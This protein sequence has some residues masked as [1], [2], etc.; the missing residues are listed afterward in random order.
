MK[1]K[2]GKRGG[3]LSTWYWNQED[4]VTGKEAKGKIVIAI[5]NLLA[6]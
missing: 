1:G 2:R 4:Q 6:I 3:P 5:F